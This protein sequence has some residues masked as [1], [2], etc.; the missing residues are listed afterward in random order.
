MTRHV[1]DVLG[2]C[3]EDDVG[4][5]AAESERVDPG[6]TWH[7]VRPLLKG[8]RDAQVECSEGNVRIRRL[9]VQG[10]RDLPVLQAQRPLYQAGDTRCSFELCALPLHPALSA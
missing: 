5:G 7:R 8:L 4:I 3:L 1:V 6:Q 2:S 9:E 10:R